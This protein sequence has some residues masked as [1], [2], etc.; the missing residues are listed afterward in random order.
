MSERSFVTL[1]G[2]LLTQCDW[3][4]RQLEGIKQDLLHKKR[5]AYER[6]GK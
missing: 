2:A 3:L 4:G 5:R 1:V 6:E